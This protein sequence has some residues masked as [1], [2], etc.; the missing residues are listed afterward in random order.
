MGIIPQGISVGGGDGFQREETV[1]KENAPTLPGDG[2]HGGYRSGV[3]GGEVAGGA[4]SWIRHT[5]SKSLSS[6]GSSMLIP[7]RISIR[8]RR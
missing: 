3:E 2:R 8:L 6:S 1:L 7:A 5:S 4:Q